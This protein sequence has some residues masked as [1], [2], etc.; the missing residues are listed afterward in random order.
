MALPLSYGQSGQATVH[1]WFVGL[2]KVFGNVCHAS[3]DAASTM[4]EG[5]SEVISRGDG[6]LVLLLSVQG[7]HSGM[8]ARAPSAGRASCSHRCPLDG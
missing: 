7:R 8:P 6:A 5:H 1:P 4:V 2:L 3:E